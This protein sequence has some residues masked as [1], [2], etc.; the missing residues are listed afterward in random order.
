MYDEWESLYLVNLC[1]K[2]ETIAFILQTSISLA[3]NC[4][5]IMETCIKETTYSK[6]SKL[7]C[8]FRLVKR[9]LFNNLIRYYWKKEIILGRPM[10]KSNKKG[11]NQNYGI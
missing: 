5:K 9:R 6:L 8:S 2:R 3:Y 4:R 10:D 1:E 7:K 11:K